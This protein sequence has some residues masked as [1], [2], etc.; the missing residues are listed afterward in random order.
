M[1]PGK[2]SELLR[3][4][5]SLGDPRQDKDHSG[6]PCTVLDI[7]FSPQTMDMAEKSR[8]GLTYSQPEPQHVGAFH[9]AVMCWQHEKHMPQRA[10]SNDDMHLVLPLRDFSISS[11]QLS[12]GHH[13]STL[14]K[15]GSY[16]P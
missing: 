10:A 11:Q 5:M 15:T 14:E 8:Q 13:G 4:P 7:V 1:A 9:T 16:R 3:F 12:A 2:D 6:E